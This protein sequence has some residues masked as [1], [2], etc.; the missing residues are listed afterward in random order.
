MQANAGRM[1][2][3]TSGAARIRDSKTRQFLGALDSLMKSR[4][5]DFVKTVL[6]VVPLSRSSRRT[7]QPMAPT[8]KVR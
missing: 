5:H 7:R 6:V 8:M 3:G 1:N 4:G 2:N